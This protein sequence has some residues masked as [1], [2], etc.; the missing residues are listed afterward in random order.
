MNETRKSTENGG[1]KRKWRVKLSKFIL[2]ENARN[3]R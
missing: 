1:S 2:K 3:G